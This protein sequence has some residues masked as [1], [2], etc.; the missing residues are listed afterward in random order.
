MLSS[1]NTVHSASHDPVQCN[2]RASTLP[3]QST[4][5]QRRHIRSRHIPELCHPI[6]MQGS[7]KLPFSASC[8]VDD[9]LARSTM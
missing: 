2:W 9:N 8:T 7:T 6:R 4:F 1:A 5:F 3:V